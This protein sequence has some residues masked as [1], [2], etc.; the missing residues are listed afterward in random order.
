MP[1][2]R[3][4]S[5]GG[6]GGVG[7]GGGGGEG[8][9]GSLTGSVSAS[10]LEGLL[11]QDVDFDLRATT[12]LIKQVALVHK[13]SGVSGGGRDGGR[14]QSSEHDE[15]YDE[16]DLF[17][18]YESGEGGRED[19]DVPGV[20]NRAADDSQ[21]M[22]NVD[23][24]EE[25]G[26]K[27]KAQAA[28]GGGGG[29]G[30]GG[31]LKKCGSLSMLEALTLTSSSTSGSGGEGGREGGSAE[32]KP[33]PLAMEMTADS[34][35]LDA[36]ACPFNDT[37][38]GTEALGDT[39]TIV[40]GGGNGGGSST[41][42]SMDLIRDG[43]QDTS[44]SALPP[45]LRTQVSLADIDSSHHL[46]A[47]GSLALLAMEAAAAGSESKDGD[48]VANE[49]IA[50]F[51]DESDG[52]IL[53]L[54]NVQRCTGLEVSPAMLLFCRHGLVMVDGF[55]KVAGEEGSSSSGSSI[56]IKRVPLS[57]STA[58]SNSNATFGGA[59]SSSSSS[60]S[61]S[62]TS[63]PQQQGAGGV[64][65]G[66]GAG[67]SNAAAPSSSTTSSLST[68][69]LDHRFNVYLRAPSTKEDGRRP[70]AEALRMN[71]VLDNPPLP[72]TSPRNVPPRQG[73]EEDG[74]SANATASLGRIGFD[75][76]NPPHVERMRFDR[77]RILYKRRYQFRHVAIEFFDVD[78]RSFLVALQK[79]EEQTQVVD[80]VL[81]APLVNSVF[82]TNNQDGALQKLGGGGRINYKR[83]MAHW[84]Q[85]LTSKW[86]SG[87]M[88]NFEYLMHLNALAGRSF[89]DLTQYPVFPWV[90]SDYTSV[91]LDLG[92]PSVYRDLRKPMGAL[93]ES[94]A[95]QFRERFEQLASLVE[96][97]SPEEAAGEA[98][99]F[100]YGTHYSCAGYVLYYLLRL[101]PYARLHLQLQ[102]GKFDKADRLFRDIKS[103][104]D[105]ASRENLQDVRELIPEFYYLPE[106]LTNHNQFDYGWLQKGLAV[107]HVMLPPWAKGDA[108]EFVRL[109][110]MALESK[111]VSENLSY[112]IDLIFGCKQT[113]PEAVE[114]Q[115]LFVHLTYEGVVDIDAIQDPVI[116]EATIAQIHNFGQTPGRLFKRPHPVRRVPVPLQ[117]FQQDEGS[118]TMTGGAAAAAGLGGSSTAGNAASG[119]S[120]NNSTSSAGPGVPRHVDPSALAWHQYTTPSL[121]I[122]GAPQTIALRPT[123]TSQ[124]GAPYGGAV[125]S[126]VQPVGD[127]WTVKDRAVG[128]GLDCALVPPSLVK[129]ARY[130]S[131]DYGLAF[132]VAVPTTRH[133]YVDRVVSVHEQ[134]H[135]GAVNCLALDE[136]GELAV[137]GSKD[138]TVRVWCLSKQQAHAQP[139]QLHSASGSGGKTLSLQATLCG[140]SN[141][142][143]CV[144]V[145]AQLGILL[146]GGA[147]RLAVAWD[148][149]DFTSQRLLVGHTSPVT[150]V[151]I[152]KRTGDMVTLGGVDIRVWSVTGEPLAQVSA[153]AVV[154]E[155]PTCVVAT[156]CP[157]WQNGVVAVTGHDNGKLC[158][159][160]L[161]N[162]SDD[163]PGRSVAEGEAAAAAG[164][165]GGRGGGGGGAGGGG[166]GIGDNAGDGSNG[167][168]GEVDV[169][170]NT[171][172]T[173]GRQLRVMQ[174]LQGV[175]TA[176]ITAVRVGR[177]Q[178][179]LAVGDAMGRCS[180]W[181][182]VRLDQLPEKEIMQL[183]FTARRR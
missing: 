145:A 94:R 183:A 163:E 122:V 36:T 92:N 147:D 7:G 49:L 66:E 91:D 146:S 120:S 50:G 81:D 151:S 165:A 17:D 26:G 45:A 89:H 59:N 100:H 24:T 170:S 62:S 27:A 71:K 136:A 47:S 138:S 1:L 141:E 181:T 98:P 42:A 82:W 74:S 124:L 131:P 61:S 22:L 29:G 73:T 101:E 8:G 32:T 93:G 178:R 172:T 128:V 14:G 140:H 116:R 63:V 58:S 15:E 57:A 175:H 13:H 149:R 173:Q 95:K 5:T 148:V 75:L 153:I 133:Q 70:S 67:S 51:V 132:R 78:G 117:S 31:E 168:E 88:T 96:D 43:S 159:W 119:S 9:R 16:E 169:G 12:K 38:A 56:S 21:P 137:T 161:Q 130:G 106:F 103:S 125:P 109:Q 90:L 135:L 114:A 23:M 171:G 150:S 34:V 115:N 160:G 72:S 97:M 99:P 4:S 10:S 102:G 121:C 113:G 84:R 143:L 139:P 54:Y 142:V 166:R 179:D 110:R 6:R 182:S 11:M 154:K 69:D 40:G 127:V 60:S 53:R 167:G 52:P 55:A 30:G 164:A 156:D 104:W 76:E 126:A 118:A 157:E 176:A 20:L 180:K 41:S 44:I 80:L 85:Q 48:L 134:L 64:S 129:Y 68:E 152:N 18:L 25:E 86:Q 87:R 174:I 83:F 177:E 46:N 65:G 112:W 108:R 155:V 123:S 39:I 162:L 111:Y 37:M 158:L 28:G 3:S 144:D 105:S 79:P 33:S 35:D 107:N 19:G 2:G 77:L